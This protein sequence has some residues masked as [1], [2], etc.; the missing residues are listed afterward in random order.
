MPITKQYTDKPVTNEKNVA[1]Y[2]PQA[3]LLYV[4]ILGLLLKANIWVWSS[5]F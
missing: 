2:V 4:F 3:I 1:A 5:I